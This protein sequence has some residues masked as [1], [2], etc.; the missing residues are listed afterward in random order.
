MDNKTQSINK[1][2]SLVKTNL[3]TND[4]IDI[5]LAN[6]LLNTKKEIMVRKTICHIMYNQAISRLEQ[7]NQLLFVVSSKGGIDKSQFIKAII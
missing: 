6:L 1:T 4:M 2:R 5:I 3:I 7:S